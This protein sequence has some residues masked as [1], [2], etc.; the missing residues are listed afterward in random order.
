MVIASVK[1][2]LELGYLLSTLRKSMIINGCWTAIAEEAAYRVMAVHHHLRSG[3]E[4]LSKD[5]PN[6]KPEREPEKLRTDYVDLTLIT[7]ISG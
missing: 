4:S 1:T 5:K 6:P 7:G 2:A 3:F